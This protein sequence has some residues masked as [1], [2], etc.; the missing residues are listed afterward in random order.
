M[1]LRTR[2]VQP[3]Q[4]PWSGEVPSGSNLSHV[5]QAAGASTGDSL[6]L[7]QNGV[8][9]DGSDPVKPDATVMLSPRAS[10]G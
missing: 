1:Y 9:A 10:H 7:S 5:L 8:P 2:L 6:V 4:P 3:G